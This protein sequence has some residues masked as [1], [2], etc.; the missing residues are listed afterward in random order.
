V[1]LT[2]L[3]GGTASAH[4]VLE[5]SR[6]A[7]GAVA[8]EPPSTVELR[9]SEPPAGRSTVVVTD[10][11]RHDVAGKVTVSGR[12]VTVTL[13]AA[14]PGSWSVR[15][16]VLSD[17]DGH[18]SQGDLSFVVDG[19]PDC[20]DDVGSPAEPEAGAPSAAGSESDSGPGLPAAVLAGTAVLLLLGA[21]LA[22]RAS[23]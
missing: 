8:S 5:Q 7:Q 23:R 22:R 14:Q 1:T 10:G 11:C 4:A 9:F 21:A 20:G 18:P 16:S 19:A 3:S 2:V 13:A 12:V 15:Y 6:P 17:V